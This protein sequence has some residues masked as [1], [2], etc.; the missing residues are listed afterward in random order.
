MATAPTKSPTRPAKRA[1]ASPTETPPS[2]E[3]TY[4]NVHMHGEGGLET[5]A[6]RRGAG[7]FG[8][9]WREQTEIEENPIGLD[10]GTVT[11]IIPDLDRLQATFW[12]LYHQ[13]HKHHWLVVGPSFLELHRFLE[14]HYTEVHSH[15]DAIAERMTALGGIPTSDPVNQARLA[16]V[17]HEPEGMYRI[18]PMLTHDRAAEATLAVALRATIRTAA[19]RGDYGT[20][21]LL[22][23]ILVKTE[24]RAHHLDHFLDS[25]T[26][27][28]GLTANEGEV[29]EG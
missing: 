12:V 24:D 23:H 26:L 20:E 17:P 27:E 16:H 22:K 2:T 9:P 6:R 8:A 3:S 13:Y 1:K 11:A 15:L 18:R 19:D 29:Q 28:V 7:R 25:Y 14:E 4:D 21:T 5:E 10:A